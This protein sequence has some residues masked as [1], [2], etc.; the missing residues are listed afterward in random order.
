MCLSRSVRHICRRSFGRNSTRVCLVEW[1]ATWMIMMCLFMRQRNNKELI[2]AIC[3]D[4]GLI[5][6]TDKWDGCVYWSLRSNNQDYDG[7]T[8]QISGNANRV[9]SGWNLHVRACLHI[10]KNLERFKMH[11][12]INY[13]MVEDWNPVQYFSQFKMDSQVLTCFFQ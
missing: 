8:L 5:A 10:E 13:T 12:D 1:L 2:V 3:V 9:M 6:G 7:C 4:D 11:K